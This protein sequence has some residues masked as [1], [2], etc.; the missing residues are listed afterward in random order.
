MKTRNSSSEF[1]PSKN[2]IDKLTLPI[3]IK[4]GIS[5]ELYNLEPASELTDINCADTVLSKQT[6]KIK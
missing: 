1:Y 5:L 4:D 3:D 2:P 6:F